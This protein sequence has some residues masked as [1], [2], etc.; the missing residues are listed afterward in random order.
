MRSCWSAQPG[1]VWL[2]EEPMEQGLAPHIMVQI[3][4]GHQ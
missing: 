2:L 3:G 1:W 4:I